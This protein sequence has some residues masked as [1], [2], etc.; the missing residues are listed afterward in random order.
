MDKACQKKLDSLF[1]L[2][3]CI[4]LTSAKFLSKKSKTYKQIAG[5]NEYVKTAYEEAHNCFIAWMNEG[6]PL[7]TVSHTNMK[8]SRK[9]FKKQFKFCKRNKQKIQDKNL[10]QSFVNKNKKQFWKKIKNRK[11]VNS[12]RKALIIDGET[13]QT[14]IANKFSD[15]FRTIFDDNSSFSF[16]DLDLDNSHNCNFTNSNFQWSFDIIRNMKP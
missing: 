6:K 14:K 13:S 16:E 4:L 10:A 12:K 8:E 9:R 2:I 7:D 1:D 11:S 3:V 5:W 15:Y